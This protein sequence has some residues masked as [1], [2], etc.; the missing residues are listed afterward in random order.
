MIG[1]KEFLS[2]DSDNW[3]YWGHKNHMLRT[4]Q[5]CLPGMWLATVKAREIE[6]FF[7]PNVDLTRLNRE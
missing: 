6:V 7:H 1:I 3:G 2:Y 5:I 4:F